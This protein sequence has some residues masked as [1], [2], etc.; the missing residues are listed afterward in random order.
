MHEL[1]LAESMRELIVD[2]AKVD[3]FSSVTQVSIEIGQL[4]HVQSDAMEFCFE[5]VM[6]GSPAESAT[7]NIIGAAGIGKCRSCGETSNIA[8]RYDPCSHCGAFGL[9]VI[10]GDAVRLV[11][12]EVA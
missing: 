5:A 12:L 8:F 6:V 7:L 11:S 3:G 1:S 9:S 2:Q 4:S 10:A